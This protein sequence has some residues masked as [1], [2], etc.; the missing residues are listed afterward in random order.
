MDALPT[1]LAEAHA[2][3]WDELDVIIV[4]GDDYVDHPSFGMAI[5]GRFLESL[6]LHV[7]ILPRPRMD[8]ADDFRAL[9]RPRLF[10]G[11]TAGN[12]DSM[13]SLYTAAR[14]VRSDDPYA[15]GG[16]AGTRPYLPT[17]AYTNKLKSMFPGVSIILGGIEAS[18]RRIAHYDHYHGKIRPP[19]VLSAKADML[20]YGNAEQP[21]REIVMRL[22]NGALLSAIRDVRGTAVPVNAGA[23]GSIGDAVILPSY[24]EVA[25]DTDAFARMTRMVI[26]NDHRSAKPLY[27]ESAGRGVLI[28]PPAQPL[29]TQELDAVYDLPFTRKPHPRYTD[30]IP[31][32]NVVEYS[33]TAHRGCYGGCAFCSL[34]LHQGRTI[35]IRSKAS[36]QREVRVLYEMNGRK[37][38]VITDIGGPTAN[39]YGIGGIDMSQCA[40]CRRQS[41]LYPAVCSN[42]GTS[43]G[44]YIELLESIRAMPEVKR[45]Y[46]NSGIR[47]DL[48]SCDDRF[49]DAAAEHYTQGRLSVA[50]EHA[51]DAVLARA[52]KPPIERYE[53]FARAYENASRKHGK[54]QFLVPYFIAGLPG[55]TN[56][57]AECL[58]RYVREKRI[59]TEQVQEFYPTPMTLSTVMFYTG[60]DPITGAPVAT[61][62]RERVKRLRKER[63]TGRTRKR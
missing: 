1:T 14:K 16:A 34:A 41:C 58:A 3:G 24:E 7:G 28:N 54:E 30:P 8:H 62:K 55:E 27:Q 48:A 38:V 13:V 23:R 6:S 57:S 37:K 61:E 45:V 15:S 43:H 12:L 25:K 21:L 18:L 29:S 9:G 50:P 22:T 19:Q 42:L 44:T 59:R 31:A 5:V 32:L 53:R 33:I 4:T 39:M 35:Q 49:I 63:L 46:V 51:D 56:E 60:K 17:L 47:Y 40:R 52:G 2:R 10:F 36:I 11:V 26:E 20:I